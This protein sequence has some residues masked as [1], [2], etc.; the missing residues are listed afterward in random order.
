MFLSQVPYRSVRRRRIRHWLL[1]ALRCAAYALLV[2]AFARPLLQGARVDAE[3]TAGQRH[4]VVLLDTS[5]S[6][7]RDSARESARQAARDAVADLTENDLVSIVEFDREARATVTAT[8]DL[9]EARRAIE[10]VTAG[11]AATRFAPAIQLARKL[12][13][14]NPGAREVAMISDFQRTGRGDD[15]L[16]LRLP[17][18]T[19]LETVQVGEAGE[20]N[21]AVAGAELD[22][23]QSDRREQVAVSARLLNPS[24]LPVA[25]EVD[26]S[27]N[28]RALDPQ[29]AEVPAS[30]TVQVNFERAVLESGVPTQG[31]IEADTRDAIV[32]DNQF[33]FVV[34]PSQGIPVLLVEA[35]RRNRYLGN[36]LALGRY[37]NFR[38]R[39]VRAADLTAADLVDQPVVILN[40]ST[41]AISAAGVQ[42]L[43]RHVDSGGGLLVVWAGGESTANRSALAEAL[44]LP[45]IEAERRTSRGARGIAYLDLAH[46]ALEVFAAPRSGD[47]GG[48]SIFR[49]H[50]LQESSSLHHT[51]AR[52][53]DGSPALVEVSPVDPDAAGE[54][55][56][57][58]ALSELT[59]RGR[60]LVW[61]SALDN[62]WGDLVLRPVFLPFVHRLTQ[63]LA[64]HEPDREWYEVGQ[65][66]DLEGALSERFGS[67]A[68]DDGWLVLPPAGEERSLE[69]DSE[70]LVDLDQRGFWTVRPVGNRPN[71]SLVLAANLDPRE[72]DLATLDLEVLAGAMAP[73]AQDVD[74]VDDGDAGV[75]G[76]GITPTPDRGGAEEG[77]R[78]WW[79]LLALMLLILG[80]ESWLASRYSLAPRIGSRR[81]RAAT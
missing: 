37:P 42:L 17:A 19:R 24:D 39:R 72:S 67:D 18:G 46:P 63:Y 8:S 65:V 31:V 70:L 21:V 2:L 48:V 61:P 36:A 32:I 54:G 30:G 22:R 41:S 73:L 26:L 80:I 69:P 77:G 78:L 20:H 12:L 38:L 68:G 33:R 53:G 13:L 5:F 29:A 16:D 47:F 25:A 9:D 14:E 79:F 15:D 27:L 58:S 3:E 28:Q 43:E 44:N 51:I 76:A 50:R 49:Y 57:P 11:D 45:R 66:V 60:V 40:D 59:G 4:R 10:N 34:S 56:D 75:E 52:F 55:E 7:T 74:D 1:L 35:G 6:M 71:D 62:V 81:T 23:G 64:A